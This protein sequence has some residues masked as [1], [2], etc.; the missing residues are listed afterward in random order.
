[1]AGGVGGPARE[2]EYVLAPPRAAARE[3]RE[4]PLS[5]VYLTLE[6]VTG[7]PVE[8]KAREREDL[9]LGRPLA[10]ADA[11]PLS[12]SRCAISEVRTVEAGIGMTHVR[13]SLQFAP[14]AVA[15][16]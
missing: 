4:A 15:N 10:A 13:A 3:R 5:P 8:R 11:V 16:R 14:S 6:K 9:R 7:S 12:V 1:M 2:Y